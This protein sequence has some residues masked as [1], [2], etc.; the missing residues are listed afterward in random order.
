MS[1]REELG[2]IADGDPRPGMMTRGPR[3][4][5][6]RSHRRRQQQQQ[7]Q[8]SQQSPHHHSQHHHQDRTG[9]DRRAEMANDDEADRELE[10]VRNASEF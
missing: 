7:Q 2:V 8:P 3:V 6:R 10:E 1:E 9:W 4:S 5:D